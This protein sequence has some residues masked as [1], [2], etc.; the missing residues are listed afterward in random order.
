MKT[1]VVVSCRC[2]RALIGV[3]ALL[4]VVLAGPKTVSQAAAPPP[5]QP[6]HRVVAMYFHRTQRC[7]T[8]LRIGTYIEQAVKTAFPDRL[9]RGSVAF[10]LIDYQN[11]KNAKYTKAYKVAKP[12]LVIADV[13]DG[14][15]TSWKPMPKVWSLVYK[16]DDFFKYVRDGVNRF[17]KEEKQ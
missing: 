8:C 9:K 4:A 7:P 5:A 10:Y 15:V 17:L 2:R 12:I 14:K 11:P 1:C 13:H 16:K 6:A 3:G